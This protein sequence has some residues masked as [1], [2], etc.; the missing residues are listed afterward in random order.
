MSNR[1][2]DKKA[3]LEGLSPT[4]A[5][6]RASTLAKAAVRGGQVPGIMSRNRFGF[7]APLSADDRALVVLMENSGID[8][9]V[10][11]LLGHLLD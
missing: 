3:Y 5:R 8:L 4:T 2:L 11:R 9:G 6:S 7:S 1:F 10:G